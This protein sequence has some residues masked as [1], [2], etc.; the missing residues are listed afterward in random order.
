MTMLLDLPLHYGLLLLLSAI[1]LPLILLK[2]RRMEVRAIKMHAVYA[3]L[4]PVGDIV[5]LDG[6]TV[7][8][9]RDHNE[10]NADEMCKCFS[11][12]CSYPDI[13]EQIDP[14]EDRTDD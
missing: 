5:E 13:F 4:F 8:S 14:N 11:N 1:G 10:Y 9:I 12:H 3:K 6:H 7:T 2:Q